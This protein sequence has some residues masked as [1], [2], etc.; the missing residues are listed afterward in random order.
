[1]NKMVDDT[2]CI[3]E[4]RAMLK[5]FHSTIQGNLDPEM[6]KEKLISLKQAA[7][8]SKL[9]TYHQTSGIVER[10]NN[11]LKGEYGKTKTAEN[12]DNNYKAAPI[13]KAQQNGKQH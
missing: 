13:D 6:I 4:W 11:Y 12:L 1:M 3:A 7:A 5:I 10:C 8:N 9:L 2:A